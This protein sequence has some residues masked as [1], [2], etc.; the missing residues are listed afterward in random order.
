LLHCHAS[1][2]SLFCRCCSRGGGWTK[3][4]L[5][6]DGWFQ[7]MLPAIRRKL[8]MAAYKVDVEQGWGLLSAP[9][10]PRTNGADETPGQDVDSFTPVMA[11]PPA[12]GDSEEE[13]ER[14]SAALGC[15]V[16]VAEYHMQKAPSRAL[17]DRYHH[18][19][20]SLVTIDVMLSDSAGDFKG[21]EFQTLESNGIMKCDYDFTCGDAL[22]FVSHKYHCVQ[23]VSAGERRVLVLEFWRG[24]ECRC[25]HRCEAEWP[26]RACLQLPSDQSLEQHVRE[27][28]A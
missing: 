12:C 5:Q 10:H 3:V 23:K 9:H 18:D 15:N 26:L 20:D 21:G 22:V 2:L 11:T 13:V 27:S 8:L 4:Y 28:G 25:P 6:T 24:P 16:R 14:R 17:P 7:R 19:S 1:A